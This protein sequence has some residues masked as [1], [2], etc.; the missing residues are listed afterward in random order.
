MNKKK[1]SILLAIFVAASLWGMCP[2]KH[3]DQAVMRKKALKKDLSTQRRR[4]SAD[5]NDPLIQLKHVIRAVVLQKDQY[6][7]FD[8]KPIDNFLKEITPEQIQLLN[9]FDYAIRNNGKI[10]IEDSESFGF[11]ECTTQSEDSCSNSTGLTSQDV[12]DSL[13]VFLNRRLKSYVNYSE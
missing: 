13:P 2:R 1:Y 11:S 3:K 7:S 10:K 6:T 9:R 5:S 4:F 12:Y 8:S